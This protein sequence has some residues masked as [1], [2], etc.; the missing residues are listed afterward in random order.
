MGDLSAQPT[1]MPSAGLVCAGQR[2]DGCEE[3]L[4]APT[5][6]RDACDMGSARANVVLLWPSASA[7]MEQRAEKRVGRSGG[8]GGR[9]LH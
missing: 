7:R 8:W 2:T 1:V 3:G 6:G 4:G 5:A 9:G